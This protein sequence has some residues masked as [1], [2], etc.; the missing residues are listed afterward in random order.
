[1]KVKNIKTYTLKEILDAWKKAYNED[2]KTEYKGFL[3][4]L[5]KKQEK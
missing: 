2:I 5:R 4:C 1:M 3:E